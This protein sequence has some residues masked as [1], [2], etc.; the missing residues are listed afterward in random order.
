MT[1]V[2]VCFSVLFTAFGLAVLLSTLYDLLKTGII[3]QRDRCT[4][5]I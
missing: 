2:H 4:E 1:D 5:V 3:I